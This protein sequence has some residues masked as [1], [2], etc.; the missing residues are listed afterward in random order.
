MLLSASLDPADK[1]RDVGVEADVDVGVEA[2]VDVGVEADAGVE[3][4]GK[5]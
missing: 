4:E 2:D 3:E 1:P 5:S